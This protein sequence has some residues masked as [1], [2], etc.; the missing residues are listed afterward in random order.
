MVV[1]DN[2]FAHKTAP[3]LE[4]IRQAGTDVLFLPPYSPEF[5]PIEKVWAKLKELLRRLP[6]LTR[7]ALEAA[8]SLAM[9][10]IT[11]SDLRAWTNLLAMSSDILAGPV[12][13]GARPAW[14]RHPASSS[15]GS[16]SGLAS[17]SRPCRARPRRPSRALRLGRW[18]RPQNRVWP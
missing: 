8:L 3:A 18:I 9:D 17:R 2:L 14:P 15:P 16:P 11:Q 10:A 1:L 4:I 12:I 6:I 7:A 5:N 13:P